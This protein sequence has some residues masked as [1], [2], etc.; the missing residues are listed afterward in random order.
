LAGFDREGVYLYDIHPDGYLQKIKDYSATG[1]GLMHMNP[2]LDL[3]YNDNLTVEQGVE[4]AIEALKSSTQRDVASGY[5]IDVFTITKDGI[6]QVLEQEIISEYRD[7]K[8]A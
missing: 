4:L 7:R 8:A 1:S 6:K 2:I 3:E 5:G